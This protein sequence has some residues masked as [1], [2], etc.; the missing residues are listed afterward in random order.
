MLN[1]VNLQ[2]DEH[3]RLVISLT[4]EGKQAID[5]IRDEAELFESYWTNGWYY[6]GD[7]STLGALSNAPILSED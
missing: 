1:Y 4:D 5:D 6:N 2:D 7:V 3:G